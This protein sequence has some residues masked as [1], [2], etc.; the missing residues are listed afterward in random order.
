MVDEIRPQRRHALCEQLPG[1]ADRGD[2][3]RGKEAMYDLI[4]QWRGCADYAPGGS[5]VSR[6]AR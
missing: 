5:Q 3:R 6:V 2:V 4:D 1:A